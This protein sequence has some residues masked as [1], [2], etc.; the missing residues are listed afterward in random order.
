L[1]RIA[2]S[3]SALFLAAALAPGLARAQSVTERTP[4]LSGGW[5]GVPGT[6]HFNFLH[7]FEHGDPPA[8]KVSNFPT[9]LMG[10][11]ATRNLLFA[12]NY[13]TNSDLVPGYPNEW[14]FMGRVA[15]PLGPARVALTA[16]YNLA[17]ESVDGEALARVGNDRVGVM[18]VVRAFSQGF[19]EDERFALGGGATLALHPNVVLA[20]DA[21][22]LLERDSAAEEDVAW[23]AGLQLRIPSTPHSLSLHASNTNTAT[24]QGSSRGSDEVRWGFEFTVPLTLRRWFGSGGGGAAGPATDMTAQDTVVVTIRD[25]EFSPANVTIRAGATV[26]WV[27]EGQVGHTAT[28]AGAFDTGMIQPR[29]RASY[30]FAQAGEHSY[31]CTPHPFMTGRITVSGGDR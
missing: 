21:V 27:N 18:G 16:G 22:T 4:N 3:L 17:A 9:F 20:G 31:L 1:N 13:A 11:T 8:R 28:A 5:I 2:R 7:R 23:S 12:A 30:T 10:Y 24:L 15:A 26:V 14:E 29:G 6:A 25:F 19:G